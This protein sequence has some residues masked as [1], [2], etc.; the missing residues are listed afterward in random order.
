MVKVK[1]PKKNVKN[2]K[3]KNSKHYFCDDHWE[4][5]SGFWKKKSKVI[6]FT[7]WQWVYVNL[8]ILTF[9]STLL[10]S[11]WGAGGGCLTCWW[12]GFSNTNLS[13]RAVGGAGLTCWWCGFSNTNT[14]IWVEVRMGCHLCHII[15]VSFVATPKRHLADV[16]VWVVV[17]RVQAWPGR[18]TYPSVVWNFPS[19]REITIWLLLHSVERTHPAT[20]GCPGFIVVSR[21]W[22]RTPTRNHLNRDEK[23]QAYC[24]AKSC[25]KTTTKK[26]KKKKKWG[27]G[28]GAWVELYLSHHVSVFCILS[29]SCHEHVFVLT[30]MACPK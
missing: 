30:F 16:A 19:W 22:R 18:L 11:R 28:W 29:W 21:K 20:S 26:K 14:C 9:Y 8:V 10:K 23:R 6:S 3:V 4:E 25:I 24:F 2:R 12:Y 13:W 5:N 1:F 27:G 7:V 17:Q 15:H